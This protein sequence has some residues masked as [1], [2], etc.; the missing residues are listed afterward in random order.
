MPRSTHDRASVLAGDGRLRAAASCGDGRVG[1]EHRSE[2][3]ASFGD[4]PAAMM[5]VLRMAVRETR[6]SWRRL[7]FFFVCI[8]VGVAAIVALR[9]VIQSVRDVFGSEARGA[10]RRRRADSTNREWPAEARADDRSTA[11]RGRQHRSDR[12]DRDA[13]DGA[14]GGSSRR[15]SRR[16]SSCAPSRAAFR[17]T[18]RWTLQAADATRTRCSSNHGVLVRPELLTALG[19]KVGDQITIGRRRSRSAA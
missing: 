15:R 2:S 12:N 16:W 19:V 5:F 10:D 14:A 7:L 13:D 17:S 1:R 18:A 11:R 3:S 8:A 4:E 9:S 6:A